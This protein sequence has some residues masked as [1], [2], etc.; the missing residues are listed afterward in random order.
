MLFAPEHHGLLV[1]ALVVHRG[2]AIV[3]DMEELQDVHIFVVHR[4]L[5]LGHDISV[6]LSA[7][8][9]RN[10]YGGFRKGIGEGLAAHLLAILLGVCVLLIIA[11]LVADRLNPDIGFFWRETLSAFVH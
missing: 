4:D 7:L 2:L 1:L 3:V 9:E 6:E 11:S 8:A 5:T 10:R